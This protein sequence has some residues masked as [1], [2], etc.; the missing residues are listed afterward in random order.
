MQPTGS[1][2]SVILRA[3]SCNQQAPPGPLSLG[4]RHA[5]NRLRLVRP[6]SLLECVHY[7]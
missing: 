5:T 7:A 3:A 6:L 2:W 1:A 4:L